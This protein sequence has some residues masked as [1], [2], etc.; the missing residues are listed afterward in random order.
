MKHILFNGITL[1]TNHIPD[2]AGAF[3]PKVTALKDGTFLVAWTAG[4]GVEADGSPNEDIFVRRLGFIPESPGS[5][6]QIMA[7][8][9]SLIHLTE[10]GDQGLFQ[11]SM[12]TLADGRV[13]LAYTSETGDA[14]NVNNLVY[15]ILDPRDPL[16]NGTAGNDVITATPN[17]ST[18]NGLGGDDKLIGQGSND[19][20]N[21]GDGNDTLDG[22]LGNDTLDGGAGV[23]TASFDHFPTPVTV[24]LA[25]GTAT[26]Q[27]NDI[28]RD[29]QKVIGSNFNDTIVGNAADNVIDGGAGIDT[30]RFDGVAAAVMVDLSMETATGQGNDTL[31]HIENVT[32]SSLN[33]T[34]TGN[35]GDNVIDGG[36]GTDTV[37]F[38]GVAAAVTVNLVNGTA[39]GQGADTLRNIENIVGS[40]LDDTITGNAGNNVVDG[41]TGN[42]TVRFDGVA[43]AVTVNLA[44]GIA[45]G[46]GN[47]TLRNIEN[48]V[49]SSLDDTITGNAGNNVIDGGLGNNTIDGG[50][51]VNTA[52]FNRTAQA[53]TVDLS[54]GTATGQ[55]TDILRNIQNVTGSSR[56]DT[57]TGSA[58]NNV[59]DG[60][61]GTDFD[62][63]SDTIRLDKTIFT[64][65]TQSGTLADAAFFVGSAAHDADDRITYNSTTGALIYDSN[66]SAAGGAA[67]F[68]TL[69]PN[70]ALHA[71]NFVVS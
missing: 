32:G 22:G 42:D 40:S 9:G 34:I 53:V 55:G 12:T 60:G 58:G 10:P 46:Q 6:T 25:K 38:D 59:I 43:A 20:L 14:T 47:D 7:T 45:T 37:R 35:A 63:A 18:I 51:G 57:I 71:S 11:M 36:G 67:Q 41:G 8:I 39:A 56:N 64:A 27:G 68:A 50:A 33:D 5:S 1:Q 15:R 28:M 66:G 29:I 52:A 26:G 62:P 19:V 48:V 30:V 54:K 17:D 4:S 65:L 21:G 61:A 23:N 44:T 2:S 13:L 24:N 16:I 31:L 3:L 69:Q 49:G 70:L